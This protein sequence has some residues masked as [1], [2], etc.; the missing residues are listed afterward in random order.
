MTVKQKGKRFLLRT[1]PFV[2]MYYIC[3][4]WLTTFTIFEFKEIPKEF[5]AKKYFSSIIYLLPCNL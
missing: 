4:I 1:V 3:Q 5:L 2:V